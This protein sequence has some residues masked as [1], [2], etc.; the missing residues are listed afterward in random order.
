MMA[1]I[2]LRNLSKKF[3]DVRALVDVSLTIPA[4]K[5]VVL[6]GG[7]GA[8]KTTLLRVL[9]GLETLDSGSIFNGDRDITFEAAHKRGIALLSQDYAIYPHLTLERNLLVAL[10]P[11][12][13]SGS[14]RDERIES[15]LSWFELA[16]IRARRPSQL[17][18][19]QLQ[20]AALAKAI[21]RRPQLLVLD[22]P[23]SQL[24]Q[25]LK[26]QGRALIQSCTERFGTTLVMVTHDPFD[27][28]RMA[29]VV[30]VMERG[31][32][33][34]VD[35]PDVIYRRPLSKSIAE[36]LSPFGLNEIEDLHVQSQIAAQLNSEGKFCFRPEAA[37]LV[38]PA[39]S[40]VGSSELMLLGRV[41]RLQFLGFAT[42]AFVALAD[43]TQN[44]LVRILV[45]GAVHADPFR[46]GQA[47]RVR[48]AAKDLLHFAS[49][50]KP[51]L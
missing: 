48:I 13:L 41:E 34:Q 42:L 38:A 10:E 44:S 19:G 15:V 8:G 22:E 14:D 37:R 31:E 1:M 40:D 12:K 36:I 45:A 9:A 21:V 25:A 29:D 27:A 33:V 32:L 2:T 49:S 51:R 26:E 47:V 3:G 6:I 16:P 7:S 4:G 28:L 43:A 39:V 11:L 30:A 50:E 35:E 17:S 23:L 5:R 18:G 46:V 24:D 20:R